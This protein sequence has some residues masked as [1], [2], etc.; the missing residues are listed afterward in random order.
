MSSRDPD[1]LAPFCLAIA[2]YLTTL[3]TEAAAPFTETLRHFR[4]QI[5]PEKNKNGFK[6]NKNKDS[7]RGRRWPPEPKVGFES[8][9]AYKANVNRNRRNASHFLRAFSF[10]YS[11]IYPCLPKFLRNFNEPQLTHLR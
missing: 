9:L 3:E 2:E 4:T 5:A 1:D 11:Q 6:Y 7:Q 10:L 8:L